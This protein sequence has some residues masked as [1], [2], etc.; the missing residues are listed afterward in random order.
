[1]AETA[2]ER[3]VLRIVISAAAAT[4]AMGTL[5][6]WLGGD[7]GTAL[8]PFVAAWSVGADAF[9]LVA[10]AA[11]AGAVVLA[12]RLLDAPAPAFVLASYAL[13]LGLGLALAA[14]RGGTS[15]W[16]HVFD[17]GPGGSF[18]APNE[19]LPA[20]PA[21]DYGTWFYLDR[22]AELVPSWPVNV[23][24][25]PPAPLLVVHW[26]D[27]RSAGGL[28]TLCIVAGS[29]V[30]PLTYL[31]GRALAADERRARI[32]AL[33]CALS[34]VVLLFGVTSY[35]YVYA[36]IGTAAAAALVAR[37]PAV[38]AAG[39]GLLAIAS[40][41]SWAL[42]AVGAFATFIALRRDG[43][44]AAVTLAAG[45]A[46]AVV[47]ANGALAVAAGYDPIGTLQATE[48]VYRASIATRRPYVFWAFGSPVAWGV[49]LGLPLA[50]AAIRAA[51]RRDDAALA[52][53]LVIVIAAVAGFTKAETERIWL[54]MVPWACVAA[55]TVIDRERLRPTL[56]LLALQAIAAAL[57]L[58][59]VW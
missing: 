44:R 45:C 55:A 29:A 8:P 40:L 2:V 21:V 17:L 20:L 11:L 57:V 25:H 13:V 18:E 16:S 24:G 15:A 36:A 5:V 19:Y 41:F 50:A 58:D 3:R 56:A 31:L 1:M 12:P 49:M 54:F 37:R 26:L 42:L 14:A 34:P 9:A 27:I 51:T 38:R 4:V 46:L 10:V 52:L 53:A 6:R 22:F 43:V 35:D 47:A 33:L 39:C 59:T 30:A 28:A 32:A 7:L 48:S 23:A